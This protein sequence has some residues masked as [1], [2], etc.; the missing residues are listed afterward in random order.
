M[1]IEKVVAK[2]FV[3]NDTDNLVKKLWKKD[4]ELCHQVAKWVHQLSM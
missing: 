1:A 3:A 2:T 4:V